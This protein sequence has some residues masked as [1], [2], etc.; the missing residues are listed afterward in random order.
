[1]LQQELPDQ[2]KNDP[3]ISQ[4]IQDLLDLKAYLQN[5]CGVLKPEIGLQNYDKE[6]VDGLLEKLK[7]TVK[8]LENLRNVSNITEFLNSV[9][10]TQAS[11]RRALIELFIALHMFEEE[12]ISPEHAWRSYY[13]CL[14]NCQKHLFDALEEF[15]TTPT[16]SFLPKNNIG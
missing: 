13:D 11:I 14:I 8:S 6:N 12:D 2:E 15:D 5:T 9:D 10:A 4:E 16:K 1:M 7:N 3:N